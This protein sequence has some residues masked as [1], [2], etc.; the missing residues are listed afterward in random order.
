MTIGLPA[1][2]RRSSSACAT[3]PTRARVSRQLRRCQAPSAP[4]WANAS[5][6]GVSRAQRSSHSP[7]QRAYGCSF[8]GERSTV[9][10]SARSERRV[11]GGASI[12]GLSKNEVTPSPFEFLPTRVG[13]IL[14]ERHIAAARVYAIFR[15]P[16]WAFA[17]RTGGIGRGRTIPRRDT[18]PPAP[19]D[20]PLAPRHA[21]QL[22]RPDAAADAARQPGRRGADLALLSRCRSNRRPRRRAE[23]EH[24]GLLWLLG[25]GLRVAVHIRRALDEALAGAAVANRRPGCARPTRRR[26]AAARVAAA[27]LRRDSERQPVVGRGAALGRDLAAAGGLFRGRARVAPGVRHRARR[28]PVRR[29]DRLLRHRTPD[30]R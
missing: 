23:L 19:T 28:R 21:T 8:C 26:G 9:L 25:A 30:A 17:A 24:L 29:R 15:R 13:A 4:R 20:D 27:G 10:P 12:A 11:C 14:D 7:I 3:L 5:V 18:A 2:R 1:G 6:S 22:P 16:P